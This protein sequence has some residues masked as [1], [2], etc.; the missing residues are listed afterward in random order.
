MDSNGFFFI[1]GVGA[2]VVATAAFAGGVGVTILISW[3][4]G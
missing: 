2:A 4:R 3:W 1:I